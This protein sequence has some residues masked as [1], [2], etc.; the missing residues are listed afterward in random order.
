M[1]ELNMILFQVYAGWTSGKTGKKIFS[2]K[3]FRKSIF[4]LHQK[5][6][7][8]SGGP[9][10]GFASWWKRKWPSWGGVW[11]MRGR[12]RQLSKRSCRYPLIWQQAI[13]QEIWRLIKFI[14][15]ALK[16]WST[17]Y[18]FYRKSWIKQKWMTNSKI[19]F[20]KKKPIEIFLDFF[21]F[22][23]TQESLNV[24]LFK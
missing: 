20:Y 11:S 19:G 18:F 2:L 7:H 9:A 13:M 15:I 6:K 8:F 21:S 4:C 1:L 23:P 24:P 14:R 16:L 17:K 5:D 10:L 3:S 12:W 22:L